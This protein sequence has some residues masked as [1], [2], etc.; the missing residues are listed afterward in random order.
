MS[1]VSILVPVYNGGKY[2]KNTLE[3]LLSQTHEDFEI[4]I[5]DDGSTDNSADVIKSFS[6]SR[7][8]YF[9]QENSGRPAVPRNKALK[10]AT[11]DYIGLCDQDDL[12]SE[13]KLEKQ[14]AIFKEN[15]D[16]DIGIVAAEANMIDEKS[17]IIGR[18]KLKK[19]GYLGPEEFFLNLLPEDFVTACSVLAKKEVFHELGGF[20][21]DLVGTDDYEMW[22]RASQKYGFYGME[23][24]LCSWRKLGNSL[25]SN[26]T[27]IYESSID[28]INSYMTKE[29]A[30][31][32][33]EAATKF[34]MR[35][36]GLQLLNK[37][38]EKAKASFIMA[39][40]RAQISK[41]GR[42]LYKVFKVSPFLAYII[43]RAVYLLDSERV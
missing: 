13:E 24:C 10:K 19:T 23:E 5:V 4:L 1:K 7:I 27:K 15:R 16:S 41:K 14:L 22:L 3:S 29:R 9:K 18:I 28:I 34:Y 31:P 8:K 39:S 35:I 38:Y 36:F 17:S 25:S 33:N 20:K 43:F 37:E 6:D 21:E 40:S 12:W 11:G 2:L 32:I 30:R 26:R 42:Y